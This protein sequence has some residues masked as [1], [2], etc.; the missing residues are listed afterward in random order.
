MS[1]CECRGTM[2]RVCIFTGIREH[3]LRRRRLENASGL[4]LLALSLRLRHELLLAYIWR[5]FYH[6]T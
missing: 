2:R 6:Y 4:L 1:E 3:T 5:D